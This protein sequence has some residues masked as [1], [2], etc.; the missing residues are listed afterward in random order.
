MNNTLPQPLYEPRSTHTPHHTQTRGGGTVLNTKSCGGHSTGET[1]STIP[2][3]EAKPGS[4]NGTA[5]D[6][7]WESRTPP[8]HTQTRSGQKP[9]G[10]WPLPLFTHPDPD[11]GHH[12]RPHTHPPT[13]RPTHTTQHARPPQFYIQLYVGLRVSGSEIGFNASGHCRT[14]V[15]SNMSFSLSST[16][17]AFIVVDVSIRL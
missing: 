14:Y 8:Q 7:L 12:T 6:R 11:T 13:I 2:N 1:P 4:A 16:V 15:L 17:D 9:Q 5:T 10:F 3:L